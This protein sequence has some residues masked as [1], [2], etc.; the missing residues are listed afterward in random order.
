MIHEPIL[1]IYIYILHYCK[2][3][4]MYFRCK[5]LSLL[6]LSRTNFHLRFHHGSHVIFPIVPVNPSTKSLT[7]LEVLT[8]EVG[9]V[10]VAI[11]PS[12]FV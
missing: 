11:P 1:L 8:V 10:T 12:T 5:R 4:Y 3:S 9:A 6:K 7:C 2:R